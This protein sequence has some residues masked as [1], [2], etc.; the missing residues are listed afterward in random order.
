[1]GRVTDVNGSLV[2]GAQVRFTNPATNIS[3]VTKTDEAGNYSLLYVPAGQYNVSVEAKGF[4]GL[5][6][7]QPVEVRVGDKLS[8]DFVLQVGE[9]SESVTVATEAPLLEAASA[10]AGQVVDRKRI[11]ELPLSDGNPFVLSRLAPGVT[12]TGDLKFSRLFDNLGTSSVV[13]NGA[14]G[15]NE[16]SLDGS[17]NTEGREPRVAYVPPADAVQE[18]KVVTAGFDAQQ[19]HAAG[20]N[21]D[22]TLRSGANK[23]H[24]SLYEFVRNDVL[25]TNDFFLNRAGQ[26]RAALRYNRYGGTVG[27]PIILPRFGEGGRAVLNGRNRAFFFFSFEGLRDAFPEPGLFTVPTLAE[28]KGDF[29]ALLPLGIQIYDPLTAQRVGNRIQ[30]T[31]FTNNIILPFRLSSIALNYLAFFPLPNQPATD[32]QGRNNFISPSP[33]SDTFNS[34]SVRIDYTFS[35]KHNFFFHYTRNDRREDRGNWT[36]VVGGIHPTGTFLFRKNNGATFDDIY[37]VSPTVVF[38][39]RAGFIRFSSPTVKESEGEFNP[40]A[41]GFSA[42]TV[43]FFGGASYLPL[44]QID[45]FSPIGDTLGSPFTHTIYSLQPTVS[46]LSG[47]HSFRAGYDVR[48][49]RENASGPGNAAGRY[50]F[51]SDF[52]RGPFDNSAAASIGQELAAFLLGQPTAGV[53]DRNA[54]RSNQTLYQAVFFQDDWRAT[55]KLTLNLGLRYEYEGAPTERFNRNIRGFDDSSPSPIE[56]AARAAYAANPIPEVSPANFQVRGGLLFASAAH[57]GFWKADRTNF[58][59]RLGLAYQINGTTVVRGGWAIYSVPFFIDG[60]Q[61]SGFSQ[62]TNIVPTLDNGLTFRA[63]LFEPFP[64]GV[65]EPPGASLGLATLI[66]RD[67]DFVPTSRKNG[68]SQRWEFSVERELPGQWLVEAAYVGNHGYDLTTEVDS[69]NAVP[70]RFLSTG[71][72]R[73]QATIDFLTANVV[74]PFQGLAPGTTL[75]GA[76]VQRQQLLLAFPQFG[77]IHSRRNDGTSIYHS[78]QLRVEKRFTRGYTLLASYTWSRLLER[79]SLLN[80]TD[81]TYEKRLSSNDS[82]HRIVVS[83]I[84]EL[85]FGNGRRF[86]NRWKGTREKLL[87]GWQLQGIWQAQSGRPLDLGNLYFKGDP[88]KLKTNIKGGTIDAVFDTSGFYFNDAAVQF[89]NPSTGQPTGV[90]DP[91][92]QRNDPRIRLTSNIRTFPSHLSGMRGQPLNLWDLSM[93]KNFSFT[94]NFRLQLRCEFLNAFNHPEFNNPNLDP[95]SSSFGKVTSQGNLPRNVQLGIKLIF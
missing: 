15:G 6:L 27:G 56:A 91:V 39:F 72:V 70:R 17:P 50:D 12:Y 20:A 38:N 58:Q 19:G 84:W 3:A 86:G 93:I 7:R 23:F 66:G 75:N 30:R 60:V 88:S 44:F 69:L 33:R 71:P 2:P 73:D 79:I 18:F 63:N 49:Y 24:G 14:P 9:V 74:N 29:S 89:I 68:Q 41:L 5:V 32:A 92:K 25:S 62:S 47:R 94:E 22:V 26:P 42:H 36:G 28:R 10:T 90:P 87:G 46:K 52:T 55:N 80:P 81:T 4:K 83:G 78:A 53:I 11:S 21:I 51:H 54:A 8:L 34:E 85:P 57:R 76:T 59:P 64:D 61:Q 31:P 77:N 95:T 37:T 35:S 43:S 1:V 48:A 82:P 65:A 45:Q 13:A 16:F 67:L 40:A